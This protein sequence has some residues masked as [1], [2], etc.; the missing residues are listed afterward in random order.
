MKTLLNQSGTLLPSK[1]I[2]VPVDFS[3]LSTNALEYALHLAKKTNAELH[4]IHAY[5][6]EIFMYDSVQISQTENDLEK[7]ILQQL[8]KLK[9]TIHLTN[10]GLKI[11]Y[12]AI[13][14][15]PVDEINAY[16]QKEK[17]DLIVIGTQG[18]GYIQERMLG[19]TASLLI[20]NAKAPVIIIDKTVKFKDPKQ[21]V[22]A[23]DF[24]KTD[25]TKVLN[26][27]K[28]F[29]KLYDSH[30]CILNI[31][32]H[33]QLIPSLEEIPEG[34]RLD[35]SLKD[36]KH[37]FFSLESD[38]IIERINDFVEHHKI[39]MIA[40]IARKHSFFSRIFREPLTKEMSFHSH[41]PLLVLHD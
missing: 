3:E 32:P 14:G 19:S 16:T 11:V 39:E 24:Q 27:L 8:E 20:R 18:A 31:Y 10:P 28:D 7:E 29:A 13:I 15:V 9:Q 40:M 36:V 25:H 1:R 4:L 17:I 6:F 30:I 37:T 41:V 35:Y 2:L 34:F 23:A 22:L 12:K 38:Q 21:I 33:I 5:D 26:P